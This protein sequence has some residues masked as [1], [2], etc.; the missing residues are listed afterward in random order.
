MIKDTVKPLREPV[1]WVLVSVV[2]LAFV[3]G[4][5]GLLNPSGAATDE[6]SWFLYNAYYG[7][8]SFV[9][10][11]V[12]ALLT[13]AVVLVTLLPDVIRRAKAI[14]LIVIIEAGLLVLFGILTLFAGLFYES[15]SE[16]STG[17]SGGDKAE[18]FFQELPEIALTVIPLLVAV[19]MLRAAELKS[20]PQQPQGYYDPAM[21]QAYPPPGYQ[22]PPPYP[23]G[24]P[25][26]WG[27][28]QG[29]GGWP[30]Q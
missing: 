11:E 27:G 4:M 29:Y 20:T 9:G 3:T 18:A 5:W 13:A 1:A 21:Q 10:L 7:T 25:G 2:F 8:S 26:Q 22:Q 6:D 30:Q 12:A 19:A 23:Q 15:T 14:L 17:P 16:Y 28:Q 24:N